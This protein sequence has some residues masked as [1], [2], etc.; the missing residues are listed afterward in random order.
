MRGRLTEAEVFNQILDH[1][2]FRSEAAGRDVGLAAATDSYLA[3]VLATLP[4]EAAVIDNDA[5]DGD[6][7][8]G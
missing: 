5:A 6:A 3:Q 4:E 8:A 7:A 2:W 1:L